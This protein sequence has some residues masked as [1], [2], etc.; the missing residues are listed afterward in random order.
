M[1]DG[2]S[3]VREGDKTMLESYIYIEGLKVEDK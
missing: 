1:S 3:N 2:R